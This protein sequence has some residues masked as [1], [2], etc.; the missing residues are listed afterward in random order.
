MRDT[1]TS[2]TF[3][4]WQTEL[5][6]AFRRLRRAPRSFVLMTAIVAFCVAATLVLGGLLDSVLLRPL[7]FPEADRLVRL[8]ET[9]E[10]DTRINPAKGNLADWRRSEAFEGVAGWYVMPRTFVFGDLVEVLATAQVSADFFPALGVA[11]ARGRSFTEEETAL[12]VYNRAN[13]FEGST[14]LVVISHRLGR[15]LGVAPGELVGQDVTIDRRTWS[16][17]GVMPQHFDFPNREVDLWIPWSFAGDLPRDQR[18]LDAFGR[19]ADGVSVKQAESELDAIATELG[20][21]FPE[22]NE[23]W[24]ARVEPMHE[25]VV[26]QAEPFLHVAG[27]GVGVLVLLAALHLVSLQWVRMAAR[28]HE[29]RVRRALGASSGSLLRS[30]LSESQIP[31]ACGFTLGWPLALLALEGL[32]RWRPLGLPR[33]DEVALHSSILLSTF[34]ATAAVGILS[35]W[36]PAVTHT[37]RAAARSVSAV[38]L[39]SRSSDARGPSSWWV[40]AEVALSLTVLMVATWIGHAWVRLAAVDSGFDAAGVY[41]APVLLDNVKYQSGDDS[42]TYY[43]RAL[44]LLRTVPGIEAVG[45]S[46][47]PPLSVVGPDFARPVWPEG[48]TE[49]PGGHRRADVRMATPGFFE[50]LGVPVVWG[51]PFAESNSEESRRVVIVNENLAERHWPGENPVG[52]QLVIDYSRSGTYPYEIIGV[53]GDL[54]ARGPRTEPRPELY[55]PHA[56]RPYL[57]MN[58][59]LRSNLAP[60]A[61]EATVARVLRSLDPALPAHSVYPLTD[62]MAEAVERERSSAWLAT[63][64][65]L[66]ALALSG[67]GVYSLLSV[68]V[69]LEQP[70]IGI[71]S[72]LGADPRQIVRWIVGRG[73]AVCLVGL[74]M[75]ALL[76]AL[77]VRTLSPRLAGVLYEIDPLSPS[78]FL[79]AIGVGA[80]LLLG[81]AVAAS[82]PPARR[83]AAVDPMDTLRQA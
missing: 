83:G 16:V 57:V 62:R 76:A 29:L 61:V 48:G 3:S 52:R 45:A 74:V 41:V 36:V 28:V 33:V 2:F 39:R 53:V 60:T 37:R 54:R 13:A 12:A 32:R 38:G 82:L 64:F 55:L 51:R 72:A 7:A 80:A 23:G 18:Y 1:Y 25:A 79:V 50:A 69:T 58:L 4:A 81:A 26:G 71:R 17:V 66:V 14:P 21:R 5:R 35:G 77:V 70:A 6:R 59:V 24:G 63:L 19:L 68:A 49:P 44:E 40:A 34:L 42:R 20:R 56:Q 9:Q 67:L 15:R 22:T 27:F 11:P 8:W 30:L 73:L 10:G 43:R 78:A 75:G 31:V 46:T 65:A 47:V